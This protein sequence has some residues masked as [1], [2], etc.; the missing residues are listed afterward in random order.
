VNPREGD[1]KKKEIRKSLVVILIAASTGPKKAPSNT[2][3][4][5][6]LTQQKTSG[7][8]RKS[9]EDVWGCQAQTRQHMRSSEKG[10]RKSGKKVLKNFL[11]SKKATKQGVPKNMHT[12]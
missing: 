9:R 7:P 8:P 6:P 1:R 10:G 3:S 2:G 4:F 5:G 12:T 11:S